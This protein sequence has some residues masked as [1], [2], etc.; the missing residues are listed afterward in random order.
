M[1][2]QREQTFFPDVSSDRIM[3]VV[4]NLAAELQVLRD[5]VRVLEYLLEAKDVLGRSQIDS[6]RGT[7]EQ[8]LAIASDRRGYVRHLLEPLLGLAASRNDA[9][10][11]RDL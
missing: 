6:F 5:R 1:N 8:E 7:E 2:Q 4:F 3:G 11:A 10:A 9:E